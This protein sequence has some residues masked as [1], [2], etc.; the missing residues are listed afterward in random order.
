MYGK[1]VRDKRIRLTTEEAQVLIKDSKVFVTN[2]HIWKKYED[3]YCICNGLFSIDFITSVLS[4]RNQW[5]YGIY[6]N[7]VFVFP[8]KNTDN[9]AFFDT[10]EEALNKFF[11]LALVENL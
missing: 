11:Q 5:Y 6:T 10:K 8:E 3:K 9:I 2:K 7:G 1:S 4:R